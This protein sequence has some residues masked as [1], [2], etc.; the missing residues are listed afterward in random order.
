[1]SQNGPPD[2]VLVP[3][4][5]FTFRTFLSADTPPGLYR[6][7]AKLLSFPFASLKLALLLFSSFIQYDP[8]P[9]LADVTRRR[10]GDFVIPTPTYERYQHPLRIRPL[11]L[12]CRG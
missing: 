2:L 10:W 12:P 5:R 6:S 1:M 4:G 7:Q 8:L 11:I 3:S 9:V